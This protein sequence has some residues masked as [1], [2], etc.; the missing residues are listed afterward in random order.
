MSNGSN[1]HS[2][3]LVRPVDPSL[4][5]VLG[6]ID[7]ITSV[8]KRPFFVAGATARDLVLA[9]VFVSG[10]DGLLAMSILGLLSKAGISSAP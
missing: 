3:P 5:R 10:P 9:N 6:A 8:L 2:V 1:R 4:V 7:E